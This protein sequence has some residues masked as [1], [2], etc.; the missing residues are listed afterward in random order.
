MLMR[1]K[2]GIEIHTGDIVKVENAY[3]KN[4]N[5]L[6]FIAH[7]PGD[8]SWCGSGYSL[9][10]IKKN[11]EISTATHNIGSWPIGVYVNDAF[12]R[13]VAKEHNEKNATIE[14]IQGMTHKHISDYFNI[15]ADNMSDYLNDMKWRFG[16]TSECYLQQL[17]IQNHYYNVSKRLQE[18]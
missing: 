2:N 12:K 9:H 17:N 13:A 5:G 11:G 16:D 18:V 14:V 1:D 15:I 3:F 6:Y 10:K 4:D 8:P 7:A